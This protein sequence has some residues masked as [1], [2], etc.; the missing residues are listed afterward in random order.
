MTLT[1]TE[2][3]D[4]LHREG[5]LESSAVSPWPTA[6]G[7]DQLQQVEWPHLFPSGRQ[8]LRDGAAPWDLYGDDWAPELPADFIDLMGERVGRGS[9][10]LDDHA[11]SRRPDV[12][13]W[14]QPMHFHGLDWGIYIRED[15]LLRIAVDIGAFLPARSVPSYTLAKA[16][17][18]AAFASLFLHEAYHH[19]TESLGI[20]L[21]VVERAGCYVP[22]FKRVYDPLRA[23]GSDDLHEEA[24]ANADSYKRLA[25][26]A[27]SRWL[28]TPVLEATY[29]YLRWRFPLDPPGYRQAPKF[30]VDESFQR[31]EFRLK[32]QVQEKTAT[33]YRSVGDWQLAPRMNQSL[34][35]CRSDIWT[36]VAPGNGALRPGRATRTSSIAVRAIS[37]CCPP[38]SPS[39]RLGMN[40]SLWPVTMTCPPIA[41]RFFRK[42]ELA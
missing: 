41:R 19:K 21:H 31:G 30:L 10:A 27:H 11:Q 16:L 24:L 20:R 14:Y 37:S 5:A 6:E 12:C 3:I 35:P 13:A 32:S 38:M 22:Y 25:E 18:R 42:F 17:I 33:P 8:P 34:F 39:N 29:A 23:A 9:G 4:Y 15:C 36:I 28:S 26:A 7:G 2:I 40:I 1:P